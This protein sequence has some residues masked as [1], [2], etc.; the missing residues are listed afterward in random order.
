MNTLEFCCEE[1]KFAVDIAGQEGLGAFPKKFTDR[2]RFVLQSRI[3]PPGKEHLAR[4]TIGFCPWCGCNLDEFIDNNEKAIDELADKSK[5]YE[6][7]ITK[8]TKK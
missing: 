1:L 2:C 3:C 6:D 7:F 5:K 8:R 4:C